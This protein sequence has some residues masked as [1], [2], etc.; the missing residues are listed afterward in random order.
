M[1]SLNS[2]I[3]V[4]GDLRPGSQYRRLLLPDAKW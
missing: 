1:Q 2:A 3:G 4:S